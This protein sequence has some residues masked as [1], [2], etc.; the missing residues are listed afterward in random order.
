VKVGNKR[1]PRS[2]KKEVELALAYYPNLKDV[3]IWFRW[4]VF[5]QHSFMLAQP[6]I[7]SLVR[8]KKKRRYQIIMRKKFFLKNRQFPNGRIPSDVMVGWLGHELGH[9]MDYKERTS[10]NLAWFGFWYYFS[11]DFLVKAEIT[12]DSQCRKTRI[13]KG[14]FNFQR[15]WQK[16]SLLPQIVCG[17][18]RRLVP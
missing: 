14:A 7:P 9:I 11:K 5:T 13:D 15:I 12:A 3:P 2:I 18:A 6:I 17:E 16:S 10:W 8:N 4:G 1:Y